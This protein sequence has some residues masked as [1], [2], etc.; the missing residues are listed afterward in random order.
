MNRSALPLRRANRSPVQPAYR[1]LARLGGVLLRAAVDL[2]WD[3]AVSLPRTGGVIVAANHVSNLDPLVVAQ[4]LIWNGRWPRI[5]AKQELFEVPVLAWLLRSTGQI[6][7]ARGSANASRSLAQAAAA[8]RRGECVL[9]YPEGTITTDPDGWPAIGRTGAARLALSTGAVVVPLAQ[10]GCQQ[11]LG[12][13]KP[14]WPRLHPRTTVKVRL[15]APVDLSGLLG[16]DDPA[17]VRAATEQTM[18][19]IAAELAV[20]R[21][22]PA[23]RRR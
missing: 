10:W 3:D 8:L 17:S 12:G 5:L 11:V 23:P 20:L 22:L 16:A 14:H 7:V 4:Y 21:G 2:D 6:P 18:A 9:V 13:K 19:A 1:R 15:G